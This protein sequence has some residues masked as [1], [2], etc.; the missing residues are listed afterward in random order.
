[1]KTF[2][3]EVWIFITVIVA[4]LTGIAVFIGT[5]LLALL[6]TPWPWLLLVVYLVV[7]ALA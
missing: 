7:G 1:M 3:E 4:M 5:M 2:L 6:F